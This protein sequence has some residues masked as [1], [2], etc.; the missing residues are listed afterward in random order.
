MFGNLREKI[1]SPAVALAF[2]ISFCFALGATEAR[3]A[4]PKLPPYRPSGVIPGTELLYEK[5][6]INDKGEVSV[7]IVNPT[8]K[9]VSFSSKFSFFNDKNE[10][11]TGFAIE[12]FASA[13]RKTAHSLGIDDLR[14]YRKATN[15]K[16]LGRSG[17]MGKDPDPAGGD[18]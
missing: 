17:R 4:K 13:N 10:Y 3:A 7:T 18:E 8:N 16:V 15:M 2:A 9:G 1:F 5:L 14:A 6:V 12:G 11:L